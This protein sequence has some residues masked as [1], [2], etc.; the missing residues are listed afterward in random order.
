MTEAC[1]CPFLGTA[2][3]GI[4]APGRAAA[5]LLPQALHSHLHKHS[6]STW[7]A[8][9]DPNPEPD[10]GP[11][12]GTGWGGWNP[13][14]RVLDLFYMELHFLRITSPKGITAGC[15]LSDCWMPEQS[16]GLGSWLWKINQCTQWWT[17]TGWV[18]REERGCWW[19]TAHI[20]TFPPSHIP[21]AGLRKGWKRKNTG[22]KFG[23]QVLLCSHRGHYLSHFFPENTWG[24]LQILYRFH[25][26]HTSVLLPQ[27]HGYIRN[28]SQSEGHTPLAC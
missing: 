14:S 20:P 17:G 3:P 16:H 15:F 24:I 18:C 23:Y 26:A 21:P 6:P 8:G 11:A 22:P 28:P 2:V 1:Q 19:S 27:A 10:P 9:E 13:F 25:S 5:L 7:P 4:T 12:H